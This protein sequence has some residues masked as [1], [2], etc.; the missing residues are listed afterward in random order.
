VG[1]AQFPPAAGIEGSTAIYADSSI[2]KYW[3]NSCYVSR[4]YVDIYDKSLGKVSYGDAQNAIGKADNEVVSLG[5]SGIAIL[6]FPVFISNKEGFDF[7]V[8]ENSFDGNFLELA[9]VEISSDS[10]HWY[11]F[12]SVSLT[13]TQQQIPTF[14]TLLPEKIHNLAG[15][16]KALYGTP[17]DISDLPDDVYLDKNKVK[18]VKVIDVI[19]SIN[20]PYCSH[21]FYGNV[22]NDP[23]PTPFY[24]G[25]FDLDAIGVINFTTDNVENVYYESIIVYPNPAYDE[26]YIYNFAN[27]T[28]YEIISIT[29]ELLLKGTI[30]NNKV[31]IT[32]LKSGLYILKLLNNNYSK[33]FKFIKE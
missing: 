3:A 23:Y 25:G 27:T 15:K 11:R 12:P 1:I 24:T 26:L 13:Q 14:G 30:E 20:C 28:N 32:K 6:T 17:F 22:I 21:D 5:D 2:I 4:G 10:I 16:Y 9:F 31:N 7:V 19:G 33:A 18:Y 29:G 8:F